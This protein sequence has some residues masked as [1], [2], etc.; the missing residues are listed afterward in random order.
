MTPEHPAPS[1]AAERRAV[2]PVE[3]YA[4]GG[5]HRYAPR[6]PRG[7]AAREP[8]GVRGVRAGARPNVRDRPRHRTP[9]ATCGTTS[10][11]RGPRTEVTPPHEQIVRN[12]IV[13]DEGDPPTE[14]GVV[15]Q[16]LDNLA[17]VLEYVVD[18]LFERPAQLVPTPRAD[19]ATNTDARIPAAIWTGYASVPAATTVVTPFA[20][21]IVHVNTA[22][23]SSSAEMGGVHRL[24]PNRRW[25]HPR[26][27]RRVSTS[28]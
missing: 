14:Q 11:R 25:L 17:L 10:R 3:V 12:Q 13:P 23:S 4:A 21:L 27:Y 28:A 20:T 15:T 24:D 19:D 1:D 9:S 6:D 16:T 7:H 8:R 26:A 2:P 22:D 18:R 5:R